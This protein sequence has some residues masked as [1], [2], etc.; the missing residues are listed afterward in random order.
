M[1]WTWRSWNILG[2]FYKSRIELNKIVSTQ[3]L[4]KSMVRQDESQMSLERGS[5]TFIWEVLGYN[6]SQV[7]GY[8]GSWG[9]T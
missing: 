5:Y 9:F 3:P 7:G 8:P 1:V 2:S 4:D 6:L